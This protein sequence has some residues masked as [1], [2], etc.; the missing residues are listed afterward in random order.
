MA[1]FP[2]RIAMKIKGHFH[3]NDSTRVTRVKRIALKAQN[4]REE[5]LLARI[6]RLFA[7]GGIVSIEIDGDDF[8]I[9]TI[10]K[11]ASR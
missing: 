2:V 6:V 7:F 1:F 4:F 9:E 3:E 11:P 5:Q 8:E 10:I